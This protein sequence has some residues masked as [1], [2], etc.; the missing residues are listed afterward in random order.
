MS[1]RNLRVIE[2]LR[3]IGEVRVTM[4]TTMGVIWAKLHVDRAPRTVANFVGLAEGTIPYQ[5][6]DGRVVNGRPYYEG[7]LFHRVIP[8]FM[9]QG[10]CNRGNGT[11]GP[12]YCFADEFH[13]TLRHDSKGVFSMANAGRDTN[14]GQFFITL[15]PRRGLDRVH[16]VFG[17]VLH[18]MEVVE[19]IGGVPTY[20]DDRPREDV[21]IQMVSV[22]KI[23]R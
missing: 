10:G 7:L 21:V 16:S 14:G 5:D 11:G 15:G 6:A 18:G 3:G 1:R 20:G 4:E 12:G 19:A 22:E 17:E 23:T 8:G 2:P 13:P 9:I